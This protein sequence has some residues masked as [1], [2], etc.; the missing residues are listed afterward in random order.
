MFAIKRFCA[1]LVV[2][3]LPALAFAG[4]ITSVVVYGDSLSDNGNLY[5]A[6]GQPPAPYY[7]GRFSNG[8][9]TVEYLANSL[10]VPLHDFAWAGATTGIGNVGDNGN[11]TTPGSVPL[12]GMLVEYNS[13]KALVPG[14][15]GALFVVWGGPNDFSAPSPLDTTVQQQIARSVGDLLTIVTGLESLGATNILVPGMPDL[16]LTPKIESMGPA[17]AAAASAYT[18]AF[19]AALMASLPAGVK[20]FDTAS[21]LR[22]VV[23]NPAAYGFTNV[24]APCFNGSTVCANPGQYLFF[25]DFHPT[26]AADALLAKDFAS[27]VPEPA[28]FVLIGAGLL[29]LRFA[30]RSR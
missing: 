18:N 30:R 24:T 13:T 17:A 15:A 3:L 2:L 14:L 21:V 28:S 6:T 10:G 11:T 26:T 20:Y 4:P 8:P 25:D 5:A 16:G 1:V 23:A 9:V 27:A 12:P 19:N 7:N 29:A 22:A